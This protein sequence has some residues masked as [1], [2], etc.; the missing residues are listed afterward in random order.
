[1]SDTSQ[2]YPHR[3][4]GPDMLPERG[5][6]GGGTHLSAAFFFSQLVLMLLLWVHSCWYFEMIR[7]PSIPLGA[8]FCFCSCVRF[9]IGFMQK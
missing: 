7:C 1:M 4:C 2:T 6:G 8:A 9:G 3:P 5:L